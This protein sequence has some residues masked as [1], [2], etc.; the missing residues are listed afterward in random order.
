MHSVGSV[1]NTG[2]GGLTWMCDLD[3]ETS[4]GS[5]GCGTEGGCERFHG[6]YSTYA[7]MDLGE[8]KMSGID[9][10]HTDWQP[11]FYTSRS[12]VARARRISEDVEIVA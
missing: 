4:V 3:D 9:G 8:E 1:G 11:T 7:R 6:R 12:A 5:C 2:D 10:D